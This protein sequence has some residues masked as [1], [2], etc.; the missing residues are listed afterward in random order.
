MKSLK[1]VY[2]HSPK[3]LTAEGLRN[4]IQEEIAL[5]REQDEPTATYA[6]VGAGRGDCLGGGGGDHRDI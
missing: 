4:I 6:A 3:K 2:G 5:L 1:D